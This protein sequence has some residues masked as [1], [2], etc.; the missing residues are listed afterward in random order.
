LIRKSKGGAGVIPR[1]RFPLYYPRG[2]DIFLSGSYNKKVEESR[3]ESYEKA[4]LNLTFLRYYKKIFRR[5][6]END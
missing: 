4:C 6:F 1:R 3:G 2:V 5:C